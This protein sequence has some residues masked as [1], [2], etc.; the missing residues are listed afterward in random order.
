MIAIKR[1]VNCFFFVFL[2]LCVFVYLCVYVVV[3]KQD[4]YLYYMYRLL[5][6]KV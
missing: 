5:P 6:G 3:Q 2:F 4:L 1:F